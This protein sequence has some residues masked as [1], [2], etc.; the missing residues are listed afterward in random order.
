MLGPLLFL[1]YVNDIADSLLSLTRLFADD[2]SL[3][4]SAS[5]LD[6]IQGL[7]NHDLILLSQWA[8]QWLVTFNPSKTEAILFILRNFD[9]LPVLK[10]ENTHI[11]FV[12][13]HKHL[14]LTLSYDGK[15]T[16]HIHNV[17]TSA[18]KVLGIMQKLFIQSE[19]FKSN[20]FFVSIASLGV[21]LYCL[22]WLCSP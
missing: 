18:A 7:I 10:F 6:D 3:F 21:C 20:I 11:K 9:H 8:K 15:W 16:D 22:G 12:E 17:K 19:R 4:Y 2:S 5:S 13:S 14:G 1:I